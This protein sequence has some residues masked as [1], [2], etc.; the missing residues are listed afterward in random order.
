MVRRERKVMATLKIFLENGRFKKTN[1]V[2]IL[3]V[4]PKLIQGNGWTAEIKPNGS[5]DC[6]SSKQHKNGESTAHYVVYPEGIEHMTIKTPNTG[7]RTLWKKR[8]FPEGEKLTEGVIGLAGG[9]ILDRYG[10]FRT[11]Q[12]QQ[13]LDAHNLTAVKKMEPNRKYVLRNSENREGICM[14]DIHTDGKIILGKIN[15][16]RTALWRKQ[17]PITPYYEQT[18]ELEVHG[19]TWVILQQ[20][21]HEG[22]ANDCFS[23]LFTLKKDVTSLN[24][25]CVADK[26]DRYNQYNTLV[27]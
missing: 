10:Y 20:L 25:P 9:N 23:I 11:I 3:S 8:C 18:E 13:F 24:I 15:G 5:I 19:A 16:G 14:S 27:W 22:L 12:F 4:T 17:D 26:P 21:Q 2:Y 6:W 1:R 7:I